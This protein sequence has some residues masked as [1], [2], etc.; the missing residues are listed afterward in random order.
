MSYQYIK[1]SRRDGF[2]QVTLNRPD[3]LNAFTAAMH[4]ELAEAL[5][6]IEADASVRA[7]LLTGTGRGFCAGQDLSDRKVSADGEAPDLGHSIEN[8]YN[9]LVRRLRALPMPVVC[10][11]NGVAAGAGANIALSCDLVLAARSARFIQ[12]FCR[13]GLIPDSGGTWILPRLVGDARARAMTLL[14]ETVGAEEAERIGLIYRV[15]D[16]DDLMTQAQA[17]CARLATQP[18]RGLAAIKRLLQESR[19]NDYHSQLD[20]ERDTQREL[21]QGADYREGVAAF[22]EKRE[23]RFRGE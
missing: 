8:Y 21:G 1:F 23:P 6:E 18:T 9:P 5:T 15:T 12:A 4:E 11:V 14:G 22:L 2:A 10:A 13:L 7:L 17:L 19:T 3:S 16:D 20:L